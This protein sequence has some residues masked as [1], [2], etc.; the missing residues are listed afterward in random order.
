MTTLNNLLDK[1]RETRSLASDNALAGTLKVSRQRV[2]A[3]R[4]GENLPDAVACARIADLTGEPLAR[5]IGIVG[6]ARAISR[7]EK[8][9][10]KRLAMVAGLACYF[11]YSGLIL[12]IMS[13]WS[14]TV[15]TLRSLLYRRARKATY[16]PVLAL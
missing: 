11:A 5:V 3:W 4:K 6:E 16:A 13:A 15:D 10:W 2:S 7:D 9:V 1:I 14:Q 8:A 12:P